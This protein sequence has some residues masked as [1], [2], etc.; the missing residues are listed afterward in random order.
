MA[1]TLLATIEPISVAEAKEWL[2]VDYDDQDEV[3]EAI[4]KAARLKIEKRCGIS[5]AMKQYGM[6]VGGF[7]NRIELPYPPVI[8]VDSIKYLDGDGVEQTVDA[9]D[10]VLMQDDY[11]PYVFATGGWP[12]DNADRPDAVQVT[13]TTGIDVEDSPPDEVPEDLKH[14]MRLLIGSAFELRQDVLLSP[15][16]Q[17]LEVTPNG[18]E[19]I[20]APYIVMRL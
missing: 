12:T 3:I 4:I 10:Y 2:L 7:S 14:A 16:R 17:E 15:V 18:Y 19:E 9:S 20:I 11:V 13:Y 5:I 1:V 6:K 8:S